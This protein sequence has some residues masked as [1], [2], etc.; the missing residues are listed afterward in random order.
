MFIQTERL[1]LKPI[2]DTDKEALLRIFRDESVAETY[3]IP[4]LP[5]EE[6]ETKLFCR[7]RDLSHSEGHYV[8]G[9]YREDALIGLLNETEIA[10]E[11]IEL[12]YAIHPDFQNRGYATEAFGAVIAWLFEHGFCEVTAGAFASNLASVKVM[13][14][15][16]LKKRKE[17]A[18]VEYHGK[19]HPCVFYGIR[20]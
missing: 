2:E 5:T 18:E 20:K 14:K 16:G 17:K 15:C 3:M 10:G 9:I 12:G 13:K 4:D 1:T 8:A 7:I 19:L 11:R 6:A